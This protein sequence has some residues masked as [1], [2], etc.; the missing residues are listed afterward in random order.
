MMIYDFFFQDMSS[1]QLMTLLLSAVLIGIN[2]TGMPGIGTLPVVMLALMFPT[3]LSTGLQLM[4]LCAAD[5][6]AVSYYRRGA[7]WKL[8]LR[9]LPCA[10]C[11]MGIGSLT[12]HLIDDRLLRTAI[13]VIIL[14]LALLNWIRNRYISQEKI[15]DHA[16]F[17]FLVGLTAGFTTQVANAAG[18]VMALYLLAMRLPKEEYM[19]TCA[20]YFMILNWI[21]LPL[22]VAEGRITESAFRADLAMLPFLLLGAVLGIVFIRKAPQKL[23]EWIIQVLVV[24]SALKLLFPDHLF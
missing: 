20:W 2:K 13:G 18:P 24:I 12:L 16:A 6:M 8:V 9:L 5:L 14:F 3:K 1:A 17:V 7:N 22:F 11:G 10:L 15:P 23:F 19:G 4:M 21:K